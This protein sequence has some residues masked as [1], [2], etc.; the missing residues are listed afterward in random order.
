MFNQLISLYEQSFGSVPRDISLLKAAGSNRQYYRM[1]PTKDNQPSI[2][3][4]IGTSAEE[5]KAFF[6]IAQ[7]FA[8]QHLN[9]PEVF[10]I[11][12]DANCYLQED[13]GN[14]SLF[15]YIKKGRENGG[16]YNDEEKMAVES[17]ICELPALQMKMDLPEVFRHCYPMESMDKQSVMF[18]LNY[19]KYCFLKL[20]G[21]E[22]NEVNLQED[23]ERLANNLLNVNEYG[24]QYRDFQAR[25]VMLKDNKNYYIDFQGGRRGP[26]YYDLASFLWQAS[27]QFSDYFRQHMIEAYLQELNNFIKVDKDEF[28]RKLSLFVFFRTLQVLGA[29]GYRG[30]WE[31]KKHFIDSIPLALNNLKDLNLNGICDDYPFLKQIVTVLT[32]DCP[33]RSESYENLTQQLIAEDKSYFKKADKPLVVRVFSFSYKKGIPQDESGNGGGYVFDCRSTHNPGRYD[34]YK[35]I[36]GLQQPVVK[37]L[38]EDGEI[39]AFLE[40]VYKLA[41]FHVKRFIDRGFTNLM[42]AFG[43]TGGQHRSVYSA[44]HLA[45]HLNQKFGIEV[46][47]CHREQNIKQTLQAK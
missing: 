43:C 32:K 15:D 5:N 6:N 28:R 16:N 20:K 21:L 8:G 31:K 39:L 36:N 22:F 30:L 1:F 14:L 3:G 13:L 7:L 11:S 10:A 42:F 26:I 25:N 38:E 9:V 44:Q 41:D 24:F 46:H 47:I 19:F 45:E 4:V 18:D 12:D 17:V 29:Y 23:F 35:Q 2:I 33:L 27:S 34:Q 40:S 37:F